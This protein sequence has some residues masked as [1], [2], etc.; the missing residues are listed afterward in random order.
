[1]TRALLL[2]ALLATAAPAAE[3]LAPRLRAALVQVY[4]TH[5]SWDPREPWRKGPDRSRVGRGFVV[6]PGVVLTTADNVEDARMIEVGVANSAR[7]FPARLKHSD[8]RIG[9]AQ[10]E[11][12]DE[13]LRESLQPLAL[14]DPVKLDDAF[15]VHQLGQDS[16]LERNTAR[17]VSANADGTRLTLRVKTTCSD[18]G[19]GQ[20]AVD[21]V[22][23]VVGLL[24][25]TVR[26][27][28]EGTIVGVETL[29]HYLEDF[30]DG[31]YNGCA[32]PGI[33]VQ[34]LLRADLRAHYGLGADR[35]GIAVTRVMSGRTGDG[36][37]REG[38]VLLSVDGYA[39]DDEG[40][41]VHEVHGRLGA[42][43]LFQG[44]RYAGDKIPV[45]ILRDGV[46]Q[47]ITVELRGQPASEQRVPDAHA[48][49]RP[50]FLVIGGLVVLELT[51][52]TNLGRGSAILR[53]YRE[54]AGWDQ[55]GER[56][57][58]VYIDHVLA[59]QANK[60]YDELSQVPVLSVNGVTITEIADVAKALETPK[61]K[62]HVFVVEGVES[63]VVLP[64]AE[65][66][67]IDARI[68]QTYKVTELRYLARD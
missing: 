8:P 23:R 37:V 9:L 26:S 36:V 42:S 18:A 57:R 66:A 62:F 68:A 13:A 4:V 12:T 53:R 43:Y 50:E 24:V 39:L 49:S 27:R 31:V 34:P 10:I 56:R 20:V 41:F 51:E 67:A 52:S 38:D 7:R 45:R 32:A 25:D 44:R 6:A 16:L 30:A 47:D 14:G 59:D 48:T 40:R 46:E 5:Q 29:R 55:P 54:R 63:D 21:A 60:G 19:N 2:L 35:H 1:M 28:Q 22:G 58:I 64:A 17:V 33:W 3:D 15:D 11:I 61:G 65:L